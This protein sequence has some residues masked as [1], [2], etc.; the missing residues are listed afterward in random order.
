M[1]ADLGEEKEKL[2]YLCPKKS[3]RHSSQLRVRCVSDAK[4]SEAMLGAR[5]L[6]SHAAGV[7][8]FWQLYKNGSNCYS[9][10]GPHINGNIIAIQ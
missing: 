6:E 10:E 5:T 1:P 3:L 8:S 7:Q 4:L 9:H 2:Q